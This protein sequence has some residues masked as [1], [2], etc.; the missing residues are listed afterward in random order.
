[1][2]RPCLGRQTTASRP[3]RIRKVRYRLL[4]DVGSG[5]AQSYT[6][7]RQDT[8][9]VGEFVKLADGRVIR[10]VRIEDASNSGNDAVVDAIVTAGEIGDGLF[11]R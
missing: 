10:I 4:V 3:N 1:M 2:P 7:E 6:L 11:G 5:P 9:S 8:L